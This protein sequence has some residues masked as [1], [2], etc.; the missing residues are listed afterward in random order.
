MRVPIDVMR[1][2]SASESDERQGLF[3]KFTFFKI[4]SIGRRLVH[5]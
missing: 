2:T 4:L 5:L 1:S 3:D